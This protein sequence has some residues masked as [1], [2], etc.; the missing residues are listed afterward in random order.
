MDSRRNKNH[1]KVLKNHNIFKNCI[2]TNTL[3][4]IMDV[5]QIYLTI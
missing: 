5:L 3:L 1:F 4:N 2:K